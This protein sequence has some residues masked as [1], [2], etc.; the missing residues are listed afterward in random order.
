MEPP[1]G[2]QTQAAELQAEANRLVTVARFDQP[3]DAHFARLLLEAE[4]VDCTVLDEC[5]GGLPT[6]GGWVR[7]EVRHWQASRARAL[8]ADCEGRHETS[9]DWVTADLD[10]PRCP[11]CGSLR[12]APTRLTRR[13]RAASWLLLGLPLPF[14]RRRNGCRHCGHRWTAPRGADGES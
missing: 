5:M 7:L 3:H 2:T 11:R 4:G 8:L 14:V 13:G 10:A 6:A 1:P 9:A 12:V